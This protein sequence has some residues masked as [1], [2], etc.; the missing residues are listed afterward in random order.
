HR[1][2]HVEQLDLLRRVRAQRRGARRAGCA[3]AHGV[4]PPPALHGALGAGADVSAVRAR[5]L[6]KT[7]GDLVAVDGIDFDVR[8][9]EC[10]GFLGPNGAGKT[11][12]MKMIYG[13]AAVDGGELTVLDLDARTQ[14]REVKSRIGVVPQEENLD[15]ELTVRENLAMQA[16]FHGLH[17]DG[18]IEELLE[19]ALL[20]NRAGDRIQ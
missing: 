13:L 1:P 5:S 4:R 14:R 6:R 3:H 7:F 15:R 2:A 20:E 9:G 10:F 17:A 12:T 16:T 11:T 19:M 8:A 18:R